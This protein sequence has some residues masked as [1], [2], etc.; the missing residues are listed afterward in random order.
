MRQVHAGAL[1]LV[2]LAASAWISTK[3][4]RFP[5][6]TSGIPR[7]LPPFTIRL[8]SFGLAAGRK[9]CAGPW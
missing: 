1:A 6:E 3:S 9:V 8:S 5:S 2:V 7:H 4:S